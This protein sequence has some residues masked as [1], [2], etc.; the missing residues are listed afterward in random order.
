MLE[1]FALRPDY[2]IGHSIGEL[3]AAHVAG[4]FSR[5]D[6]CALVVSPRPADGALPRRSDGIGACRAQG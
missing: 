4:V 5:Q 1:S 6:A 3:A 2:V